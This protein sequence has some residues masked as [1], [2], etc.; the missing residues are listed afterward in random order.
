MQCSTIQKRSRVAVLT[1]HAGVDSFSSRMRLDPRV[2]GFG[3]LADCGL[4]TRETAR[5]DVGLV[6]HLEI[7]VAWAGIEKA[8]L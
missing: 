1:T 7:V 4:I 2:M 3:T 6:G 8:G 5:V